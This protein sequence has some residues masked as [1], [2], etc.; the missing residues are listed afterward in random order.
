MSTE[1]PK[2]ETRDPKPNP[3]PPALSDVFLRALRVLRG[4]TAL[5]MKTKEPIH[6][7]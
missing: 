7:H 1:N 4:S 5:S 2:P 3:I 6:E